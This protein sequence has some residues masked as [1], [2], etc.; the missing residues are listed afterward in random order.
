MSFLIT[1]SYLADTQG[2]AIL[3][4]FQARVYPAYSRQLLQD[5]SGSAP[6]QQQATAA[7]NMF[8]RKH[9]VSQ[10]TMSAGT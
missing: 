1:T 4:G 5:E 2:L 7:P 3:G 6:E 10:D 9:E 8:H